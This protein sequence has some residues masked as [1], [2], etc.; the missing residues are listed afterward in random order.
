MSVEYN[1]VG[2]FG[3]F[4]FDNG[5]CAPTKRLCLH[6]VKSRCW[7]RRPCAKKKKPPPPSVASRLIN[8]VTVGFSS[9]TAVKRTQDPLVAAPRPLQEKLRPRK[10]I[11]RRQGQ[12]I[13]PFQNLGRLLQLHYSLARNYAHSSALAA[14]QAHAAAS[15][16]QRPVPANGGVESQPCVEIQTPIRDEG[17]IG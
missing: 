13:R 10:R 16:S 15:Q 6:L 2:I 7:T 12:I 11:F 8:Q 3:I 4:R 1:T 14:I 5:H 9:G 17:I